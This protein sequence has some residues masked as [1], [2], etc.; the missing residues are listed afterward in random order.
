MKV[1]CID[2]DECYRNYLTNGKIYD[3][4]DEDNNWYWIIN[5][6]GKEN[7]YLKSYFESAVAEIR[8]D[9]INKL[10]EDES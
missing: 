5:D 9:T 3:I 8:N 10:L 1:K 4:I 2:N 6:Y 7:W